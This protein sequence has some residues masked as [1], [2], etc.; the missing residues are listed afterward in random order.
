ML[1]LSR[2]LAY[3]YSRLSGHAAGG[4]FFRLEKETPVIVLDTSPGP[5][6]NFARA[7]VLTPQGLVEVSWTGLKDA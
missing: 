7:W 1:K 6:D 3:A 5:L 2:G 4:D